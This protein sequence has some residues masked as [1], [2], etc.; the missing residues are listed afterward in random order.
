MTALTLNRILNEQ[1]FKK[2]YYFLNRTL[3]LFFLEIFNNFHV[4]HNPYNYYRLKISKSSD[5]RSGKQKK[6]LMI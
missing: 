2:K 1:S 3:L 4:F 6:K 5:H